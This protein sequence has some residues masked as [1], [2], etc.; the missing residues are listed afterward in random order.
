MMVAIGLNQPQIA[1]FHICTHAFFKAMLFLSSGRIIHR[2]QDEQDIRK[3]GGLKFILPNTSACIVLGRLALSGI[4]FL[5]GFYSK[6]LI[7]EVGLSKLSKFIRILLSL[8]AT[9]LTASYSF[10]IIHFCFSSHSTLSPL[11]PAGE[12][13]HKL[14]KSLKRLAFGT[15]ISG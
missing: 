11:V 2:L 8:V 10:R 5:A 1:L 7:L 3:M 6:D 15:I 9:L 14:T 4:P 12:E 13:N